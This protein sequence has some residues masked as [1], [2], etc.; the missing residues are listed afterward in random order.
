MATSTLIFYKDTHLDDSKN[1]VIESIATFLSSKTKKTVSNFQY[2]RIELY[3]KIKLNFPQSYESKENS[4]NKYDYLEIQNTINNNVVS[5][6]YFIVH[7]NQKSEDGIEFEL[8]LDTLNTY[9]LS[10]TISNSSYVL[11]SKTLVKREHKNRFESSIVYEDK[12]LKKLRIPPHPYIEDPVINKKYAPNI[13]LTMTQ[14]WEVEETFNIGSGNSIRE[15]KYHIAKYRKSDGVLI[16]EYDGHNII[17]VIPYDD[18]VDFRGTLLDGNEWYIEAFPSTAVVITFSK[19]STNAS[20]KVDLVKFF[21]FVYMRG[22]PKFLHKRIINEYQEGLST[23]L[24]KKREETLFDEDEGRHWYV[25]YASANS[26]PA[27]ETASSVKYVNP[28][29]VR[30][31]SDNGYSISTSSSHEV[32]L[33]ATS[34]IIPKWNNTAEYLRYNPQPAPTLGEQYIKIN[35]VTYDFHDY[36]NFNAK[37]TNNSDYFF[38]SVSITN[39]TTLEEVRFTNVEAITFYGIN[40]I[41]CEDDWNQHSTYIDI[42]SGA[43]T[44]SG[45][46]SSWLDID[47]TDARLIKAFAFPY[48]PCEFL[49]GKQEFSR[50]PEGVLFSADNV[51]E[52]SSAQA[53]LFSYTKEFAGMNP[54]VD[55]L[56]EFDFTIGN[57]QARNIVMESKLFHSDYHMPK[58]VYDSFSFSYMLEDIDIDAYLNES[59]DYSVLEMNYV[60]SQNIQSKFMFQFPQY[61]LKRSR[62]DY[63]NVMCVERNNEKALYN[64]A[65]INYIKSGGYSYDMKKA[66]SQNAMNGVTT[67]L[68]IVGAGAGIVAGTITEQPQL[69]AAGIGL[70]ITTIGGIARSI[71]TAQEQDRAIGQKLMQTHMQGSSVQGS[72]DIDILTAFS[73]NKAKVVYYEL[74]D[75]MKQAMWDLFHYCGYATH[76]QKVPSVDTRLYFNFVQAELVFEEYH[77]NDNFAEDIKKKWNEGVTFFHVVNGGYDLDQQYENFETSLM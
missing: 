35:G 5:Y 67:A 77:F 55:L 76:E 41:Y 59:N 43:G 16:E 21:N 18:S 64:N 52:M 12:A 14:P 23:M 37:R 48:A 36:Q 75:I 7:V 2:Q 46:C 15:T 60:V 42:N 58:V 72:E 32:I 45:T 4:F 47:L 3:K 50:L 25:V 40:S 1:F 26:I 61:L 19:I 65:Y 56:V 62:Q 9:S 29:H 63:D 69:V 51:I 33:Y 49:V 39:R 34:G 30:F 22:Q 74:S 31:Y 70:A 38:S 11:S 10:G 20:E 54:Q 71:H 8:K 24:F 68:S 27:T 13:Q 6:Y 44:Y 73:G 17:K 28:V 57:A 53:P 66:S